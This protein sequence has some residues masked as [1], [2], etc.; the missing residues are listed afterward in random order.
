MPQ[1]PL[2]PE[3]CRLAV[4]ACIVHEGQL[5]LI[6]RRPT[7]V[8]AP[9]TW[10]IPGGR[11]DWGEDPYEGLR[12]ETR[13]EV[14]LEIEIKFPLDVQYFTRDDG[15]RITMLIFLCAPQTT[16]VRL[17]EEHTAYLWVP[18]AAAPEQFPEWL[19]RVVERVR[20][21]YDLDI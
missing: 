17:S 7:D 11:L 1:I 15:Q 5:L 18:L 8:H 20:K 14:T 19:R 16:Q 6:Q 10:D 4:K 13:E 3:V 9:N 2:S 12:R 21:V